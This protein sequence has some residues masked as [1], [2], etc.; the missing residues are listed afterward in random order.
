LKVNIEKNVTVIDISKPDKN[1]LSYNKYRKF[2]VPETGVVL[3]NG[4]KDSQSDLAGK[5]EENINLRGRSAS[6]IINEVIS[7]DPSDL[8]GAMEVSGNLASVIIANPNGITCD[9]CNFINT[10]DITLTTGN[11]NFN[12]GNKFSSLNVI[13]WSI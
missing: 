9:S 4:T 2:N 6:L 11:V 8:S 5:I 7:G 10:P 12:P 3:N 13:N 1:G